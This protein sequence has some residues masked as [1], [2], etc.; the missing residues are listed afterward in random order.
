MV[1]WKRRPPPVTGEGL[2]DDIHELETSCST[3][4]RD[5]RLQYMDWSGDVTQVLPRDYYLGRLS[6][7]IDAR[8]SDIGGAGGTLLLCKLSG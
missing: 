3:A 7:T 6:P 2:Q 5:R 8:G 4:K 1:S